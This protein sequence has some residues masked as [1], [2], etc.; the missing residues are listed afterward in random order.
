VTAVVVRTAYGPM[1]VP[2]N[3]A[4]V[5]QSLIRMGVFSPIEFEAWRPYLPWG[6]VV[7]DAGANIGAHTMAFSAAVGP[8]GR[9]VAV[10]PQRQLTHMLCGSLALNGTP[11][12]IVKNIALGRERGVVRIPLLDYA[13]P[14]NFGGLEVGQF[15]EGEA[16]GVAPLD[17]W[18]ME[19][20]DFLK[21]DVEG[22][23]LNVLH[24]A[25]ETIARCQPVLSVE[26]DREPNVPATLA[27]LRL[28]GY[29]AWWHRPLLGP[30]FPR[31]VSVNLLALP[32]SRE[33]LPVP[34]GDDIEVAVE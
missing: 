12:V 11:N 8:E 31:V 14:N 22:Y 16:I 6:G 18:N 30:L 13:G 25:K 9:V 26:A 7:V 10:E 29:R 19:R 1:L 33:D 17:E 4:Y 2:P 24:G 32:R 34:E 15:S 28:N 20:L 3:D 5:G 21:I 23:E 27:W